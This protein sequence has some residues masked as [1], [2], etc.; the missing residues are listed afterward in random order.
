MC[1]SFFQENTMFCRE[2]GGFTCHSVAQMHF[3]TTTIVVQGAA[4]LF[5]VYLPLSHSVYSK[6]LCSGVEFLIKLIFLYCSSRTFLPS[7]SGNFLLQ[8]GGAENTVAI[9]T[10]WCHAFESAVTCQLF[11]PPLLL[12]HR[13]NCLQSIVVV[14]II[15]II[16]VVFMSGTSR[17]VLWTTL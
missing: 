1:P 13:C 6:D 11:Y 8:V 4:D 5:Y 10:A 14:I 15:I 3:F 12:L 9:R 16:K 7:A 2:V 17:R